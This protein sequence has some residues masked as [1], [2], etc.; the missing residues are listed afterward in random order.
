MLLHSRD[1]RGGLPGRGEQLKVGEQNGML[2]GVI[3]ADMSSL[4]ENM[5]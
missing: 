1:K 5:A 3:P 2:W 4:A